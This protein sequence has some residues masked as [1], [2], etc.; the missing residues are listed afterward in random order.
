MSKTKWFD[1]AIIRED[2][3]KTTEN[4]KHFTL[5]NGTKKVVYSSNN[6]NFFDGEKW[7]AVDNSLKKTDNGYRAG[8]GRYTANFIGG[9]A[10]ESLEVSDGNRAVSWEYLGNSPKLLTDHTD[11]ARIRRG[12]SH[13]KLKVKSK[14]PGVMNISKSGQVVYQNAEGNVDLNY[15][16]SG[17]SVKED[18][19]VKEKGEEYKYYFAINVK[20]FTLK[21]AEDK[22][23]IELYKTEEIGTEGDTPE[24]IM[25]EPFMFDTAGES[26]DDVHYEIE[27]IGEDKY[28]FSVEASSEW[29]NAPERVFPIHIDPQL[30]AERT[31]CMSVS[32]KSYSFRE[33]YKDGMLHHTCWELTGYPSYNYI[34]LYAD[35]YFKTVATIDINKNN[36]KLGNNKVNSAKLRF[37]KLTD[38]GYVYL[39][40]KPTG[41]GIYSEKSRKVLSSEQEFELDI[42]SIY[43]NT[44]GNVSVEVRLD[45]VIIWEDERYDIADGSSC[46]INLDIDFTLE[47]EYQ[48]KASST[49]RKSVPVAEGAEIAMDVFTSHG[50]DIFEDISDKKLGTVIKHVYK[51]N[52]EF[53]EYGNNIRLNIDE[54]LEKIYVKDVG[55]CYVY[56]DE[57]GDKHTFDEV[58]Y[59]IDTNGNKTELPEIDSESIVVDPNGRM[60]YEETEVF[61]ELVTK[62]GL[63]A[64]AKLEGFD[65]V[66]WLEQRVDEEKQ[67]EEQAK[68]CEDTIKD[69][70]MY[71]TTD[72]TAVKAE[73]CLNE[74]NEF[75]SFISKASE[76]CYAMTKSELLSY[77]SMKNSLNSLETQKKS[78]LENAQNVIEEIADSKESIITQKANLLLQKEDNQVTTLSKGIPV[79]ELF[80]EIENP[81][82]T[83]SKSISTSFSDTKNK[84]KTLIGSNSDEETKTVTITYNN[85]D[86]DNGVDVELTDVPTQFALIAKQ[87]SALNKQREDA[88]AIKNYNP[89]DTGYSEWPASVR[90]LK[91]IDNQI[92]NINEQISL[93]ESK[94]SYYVDLLK[95]YYKE[96]VNFTNSLKKL[97]SETPTRYLILGN[98]AK[99]YNEDGALVAIYDK[100]G[101]YLAFEREIYSHDGKMRVSA[102]T[103]KD[104]NKM[105]FIYGQDGRLSEIVNSIGERTT[106][107]YDEAGNLKNINRE[108]LPSLTLTTSAR[109]ITRVESSN[110]HYAVITLNKVGEV[111]GVTHYSTVS[112]ITNGESTEA[113]IRL[114]SISVT[115]SSTETAITIDGI[116]AEVYK[117]DLATSKI[118]EHYNLLNNK[119]TNCEKYTYTNELLTK[120]VSAHKSCLNRY[121]RTSFSYNMKNGK[122]EKTTYNSFNQPTLTVTEIYDDMGDGEHIVTEC[123]RKEYEYN[124]KSELTSA[125][126]T[127]TSYNSDGVIKEYVTVEKYYY[128]T[129]GET[130]RRESC[131]E[132]EEYISG[133]AVEENIFDK[134]GNKIKSYTYNSLDSA[135]KFYTENEVAEDGTVLASL[136]A[137]GEHKTSFEHE[138]DGSV[139]TN[140]LPG[141][142]K[143]SYGRAKD[144]NVTSITQSTEDG[145]ENSTNKSYTLGSVTELKSGNNTVGYKYDSKRRVTSV[146]LNGQENYVAYSYSGD[147][148]NE[149][150]VTALL[151]GEV[152]FTKVTDLHGN[153]KRST[154]ADRSVE[155]TYDED[156]RLTKKTDSVSGTTVYV[157][158][159]KGQVER[160]E[161][162]EG[163]AYTESEPYEA[164]S[165]SADGSLEQK[166]LS[167]NEKTTAYTYAYKTTA[168]REL[169]SIST[170]DVKI[171]PK[172][173]VN[174]RNVG[175]TISVNNTK[176]AE[177]QIS[178]LKHGD[179]ATNMPSTVRYGNMVDGKFVL[180]DSIKYKYDA[181]G[182]ITEIR[183]NGNLVARYEYDT[184]GRLVREDNKNNETTVVFVYDNCG[185]IVSKHTYGFTLKDRELLDELSST[186]VNY[187]YDSAS[188][189]LLAYNGEAFEYDEIGNPTTYRGKSA[190]WAYGRQLQSFDGNTYTYDAR[191]RRLT[192]QH[193]TEEPIRFTYDSNGKLIQQ[194][195]GLEFIY[196]HAGVMGVTYNGSTFFYRKNAQN[197]VISLLDNQGRVVVKYTYDAWGNNTV[198]VLEASATAI[199][200]LNPFRYRS[201]YYDTETN[202]Y[203][204]KTRYYDPELARFMTIDGITYL[205]PDAVNGLNLYAYCLNNPV[206]YE[207]PNG[208]ML[209]KAIV[210]SVVNVF[211]TFAA[212]IVTRQQYSVIDGMFAAMAG[213]ISALDIVGAL[214][215]GALSG[216]GTFVSSLISGCNIEDSITMGITSAAFSSFTLSTLFA[217]YKVPLDIVVSTAIGLTFSFGSNLMSAAVVGGIKY[218]IYNSRKANNDIR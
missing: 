190:T 182:N 137:T 217:A 196:D 17:N 2:E 131:V 157:Y 159:S 58:F 14:I 111:K 62:T 81:Q 52:N 116:Y 98:A 171:S 37:K 177:E 122:V 48:S 100:R 77:K 214:S 175:K 127:N 32:H 203:F 155:N 105:S 102:I 204:L 41:S 84:T 11:L 143:L 15:K 88:T 69:F 1:S 166:T 121:A 164:Y 103:D 165:Y 33:C 148:T 129:V 59:K 9:E 130:I 27:P 66:E 218:S 149:Q 108:H 147:N 187:S 39:K 211:T 161:M 172:L 38:C 113:Q 79:D 206:I 50:A 16:I 44:T 158:N 72:G 201:Y 192:K 54:K 216:A 85:D 83:Y 119:V 95:R 86:V 73:D 174:G 117:F 75:E 56:T 210:A 10:G 123:A 185:N 94:S 64:A 29:I 179:H 24:F 55:E 5:N 168:S 107:A 197:D 140:K 125:R 181:M 74:N 153:V 195:D 194:S 167:Y 110:G 162:Y 40:Y 170:G 132:G 146:S 8:L 178:Y 4:S 212:A 45:P 199:A 145:E 99:G 183:E 82:I 90:Q 154:C 19:I 53:T 36:I 208:E 31:E 188:D 120:T 173:D 47:L 93:I 76:S 128:N 92:T 13:S 30:I 91:D 150:T 184:I 12:K 25:P 63:K 200:N 215:A 160:V 209:I 151:A 186:A 169:E 78:I 67:L 213:F 51:P 23:K 42:T 3:S 134:N 87:E 152:E 21:I 68:S 28:L 142:S 191:G 124:D 20:D 97:K 115:N 104:G 101:N 22:K 180:N 205:N 61:R 207:D 18:I 163:E 114:K 144:G 176:V 202:L 198:T 49:A 133:I 57:I 65:D 6:M 106:F 34:K 126:T 35:V 112:E 139:K 26:S 138:A 70:V 135:S 7:K 141:G 118:T 96:Y 80:E 109:G 46:G 156:N 189:R 71:S 60:W 89:S 136:D 193:G 43:N